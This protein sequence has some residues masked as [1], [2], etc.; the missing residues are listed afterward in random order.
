MI[1]SNLRPLRRKKSALYLR[2]W[3]FMPDGK[4]QAGSMTVGERLKKLR[5]D[6]GYTSYRR[7]A[8]EHDIEP[9]QYWKLEEDKADARVSSIKR[10]AQIH[11][12]N[13]EEFFRGVG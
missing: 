4:E 1:S 9:K 7:F 2:P 13:L 8:D 3:P 5:I 6:A 10:L 11:D 12:L